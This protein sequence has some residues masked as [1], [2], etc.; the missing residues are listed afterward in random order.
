MLGTFWCKVQI[1]TK[2]AY[3]YTKKVTIFC[4][5]SSVSTKINS[6]MEFHKNVWLGSVH[7]TNECD[8]D[9][10]ATATTTPTTTTINNNKNTLCPVTCYTHSVSSVFQP[11]DSGQAFILI[12]V[13]AHF[14]IFHSCCFNLFQ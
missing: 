4:V 8:N 7:I 5:Q 3:L 12:S 13:L 6:H 1:M 9:K 10:A 2:T 14:S 11:Y